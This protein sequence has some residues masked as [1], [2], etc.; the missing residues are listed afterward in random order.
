MNLHFPWVSAYPLACILTVLKQARSHSVKPRGEDQQR[1]FCLRNRPNRLFFSIIR[2]S[3]CMTGEVA[4]LHF[5]KIWRPI[6]WH[7]SRLVPVLPEQRWRP[8]PKGWAKVMRQSIHSPRSGNALKPKCSL[9][10]LK[11]LC[12]QKGLHCAEKEALEAG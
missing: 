5:F 3:V 1:N 12:K 2:G 7:T 9:T 6:H 10:V 4:C 8:S 11:Q